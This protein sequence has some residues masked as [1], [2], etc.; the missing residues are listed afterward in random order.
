MQAPRTRACRVVVGRPELRELRA[1]RVV[2]GPRQPGEALEQPRAHLARRLAR[3]RDRQQPLGP[4]AREQQPHHARHQQP[5]LARPRR[6][7]HG[8]VARR[9]GGDQRIVLHPGEDT[10]A[11]R[12]GKEP[13]PRMDANVRECLSGGHIQGSRR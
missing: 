10:Q 2:V 1:Q 9:V 13:E 3:E 11:G 4:R 5:G 6:G 8:G 12:A 7:G